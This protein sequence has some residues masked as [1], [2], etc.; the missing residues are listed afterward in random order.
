MSKEK[1]EKAKSCR[2]IFE[3]AKVINHIID[4]VWYLVRDAS[5]SSALFPDD[6]CPLIVKPGNN[7]WTINNE[8]YGKV[9]ELGDFVGKC[10]KVQNFP[11]MKKIKWRIK[12]SEQKIIFDFEYQLFKITESDSSVLF[13]KIEFLDEEGYSKFQNSKEKLTKIWE[14]YTKKIN[15]VLVT[16]P[17]NLFQFEAGVI[18]SKMKNIWEFMTD[19]HK[20]KKIAPL[21]KID[22]E[23]TDCN[24]A[25]P[26]GTIMKV[27]ANG[28]KDFF[29]IK[30]IKCDKRPN[31][32]KWLLVF[33]I[34]GGQPKIP[35]QIALSTLTKINYE[36]CHLA[37]FH[38]FREPATMEYIKYLSEEK[39][40]II[41]SVKDYLENYK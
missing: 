11:Q 24:L 18:A 41:G 7:T 4:R 31:W 40:Y 15:E 25:A 14:N 29:M 32:N 26:P 10:L 23:D 1:N 33:E 36:E 3:F 2:Y 13:W 22:C 37:S 20:L 28:G 34:F 8:F 35:H 39:K 38:E 9:T 12:T 19:L 17:M 16:S 6:S 27:T 5:I 30:T 21:M